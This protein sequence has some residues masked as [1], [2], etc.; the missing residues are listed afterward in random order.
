MNL[1]TLTDLYRHLEWA[2]AAVWTSV[3]ASENGSADTKL[4]DYL[5]HLHMVQY[6]FLRLWHG[7]GRDMS[8][9][10]FD[11]AESLMDWA[12]AYYGKAFTHLDTL[13]DDKLTE[14]MSLPWAKMI[15]EQLGRPPEASTLGDTVLQVA[16]HSQ[17]HRGQVNARLRAIGGEPPIVDY[18]AWVWC[19]R[20]SPDWPQ[21]A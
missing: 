13:S 19:G 10:T 17:Y 21:G 1:N 12:R 2:D 9:P 16:L 4:R 11:N 18:I 6:A 8:Y 7:E 14:T 3:F 5:Y 15:E 20:P